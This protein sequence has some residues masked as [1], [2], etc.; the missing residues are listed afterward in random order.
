MTFG[1]AALLGAIAVLDA[2]QVASGFGIGLG[3][4][5]LV[6]VAGATSCAR[7]PASL[8]EGRSSSRSRASS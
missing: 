7:S 8:A 6:F 4:A 5:F 3:V 2:D 1:L